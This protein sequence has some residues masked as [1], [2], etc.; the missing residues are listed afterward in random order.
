[1]KKQNDENQLAESITWYC[2][3]LQGLTITKSL[4]MYKSAIIVIDNIPSALSLRM[5]DISCILL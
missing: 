5:R 2:D 4:R 3:L 1:M